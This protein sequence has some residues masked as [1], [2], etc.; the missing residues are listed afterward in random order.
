MWLASTL[1]A[2][3]VESAWCPR[4]WPSQ[5]EVIGTHEFGGPSWMWFVL[6]CVAVAAG[7][8]PGHTRVAVAFGCDCVPMCVVYGNWM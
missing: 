6:A 1:L 7:C 8:D 3:T 4:V 5:L 2:M